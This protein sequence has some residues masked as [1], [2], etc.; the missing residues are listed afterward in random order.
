MNNTGIQ[1]V[2]GTDIIDTSTKVLREHINKK[3]CRNISCVI[4]SFFYINTNVQ[5]ILATIVAQI[6]SGTLSPTYNLH[7][8]TVPAFRKLLF[9]SAIV[10]KPLQKIKFFLGQLS[11]QLRFVFF[12]SHRKYLPFFKK[13]S[14]HIEFCHSIKAETS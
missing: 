5:P 1:D 4:Q 10:Y 3:L 2:I 14:L 11:G 9:A 7:I 8:I 12:K 13:M 6:E